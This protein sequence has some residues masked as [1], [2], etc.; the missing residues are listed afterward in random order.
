MLVAGQQFK[1]RS[2][3][4]TVAEKKLRSK[5]QLLCLATRLS[6][7]FVTLECSGS[8]FCIFLL[9]KKAYGPSPWPD[10][11]SQRSNLC[12]VGRARRQSSQVCG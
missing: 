12:K 6:G 5:R 8:F 4:M 11:I 3:P 10:S 2:A 7:N 9:L 1:A